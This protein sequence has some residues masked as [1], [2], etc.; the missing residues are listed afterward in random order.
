MT[1][2][3]ILGYKFKN[4]SI[5]KQALTHSSLSNEESYQKLEFLG[6]AVLE[7]VV[8]CEIYD[9][10]C[11]EEGKLT[12]IRAN[13]VNGKNLADAFDKL[14]IAKFVRHGNSLKSLSN[15]V[16]E[17]VFEAIIGAIYL[18]G[19]IDK[20][21]S[22]IDNSLMKNLST[23]KP[24]YDYKTMLQEL[25][26][27]N[28]SVKIEYRD[29]QN[30]GEFIVELYVDNKKLTKATGSSKK[31]AQMLCAKQAYEKLINK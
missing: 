29:V 25:L 3:E 16:K 8:T 18:D 6:D 9:N 11:L 31:Q 24:T 21:R 28:G 2:E 27:K 4:S 15:S 30:I 10:F 26:Q 19:G 5:L 20:A 12:N 1:I 23:L 22:F 7:F 13:I 14:Q 17:D